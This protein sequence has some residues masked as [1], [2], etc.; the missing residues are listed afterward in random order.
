MI[1]RGNYG[2]MQI[3][4]GTARSMG[5]SGGVH[6]LLDADTN[7]QYAVKYLAGAWRLAG[8][9]EARAVHYYVA[10]YYY[11]A[12]RRGIRTPAA[13]TYARAAPG[14]RYAMVGRS[15][16]RVTSPDSVLLISPG[17]PNFR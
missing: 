13:E 12:K 7:M 1:Y 6:G 8:G 9:S 16:S 3:K 11:A 10:G 15:G 4:L 5:Y 17:S 2:L 14:T